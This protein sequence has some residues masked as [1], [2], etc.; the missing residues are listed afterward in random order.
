LR[1][2]DGQ[3]VEA[4]EWLAGQSLQLKHASD[5]LEIIRVTSTRTLGP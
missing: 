4:E 3:L 5:H 1:P 2:E